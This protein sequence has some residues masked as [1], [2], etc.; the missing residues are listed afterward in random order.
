M[1]SLSYSW[2]A[3][4][5]PV[6]QTVAI[7]KWVGP[8]GGV[9]PYRFFSLD[10]PVRALTLHLARSPKWPLLQS[11]LANLQQRPT[12]DVEQLGGFAVSAPSVKK[13]CSSVRT[14][15]NL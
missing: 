2:P 13:R 9:A 14:L 8:E 10:S 6:L 5:Q 12:A 3:Q 15:V 4:F 1:I 7:L 11:T